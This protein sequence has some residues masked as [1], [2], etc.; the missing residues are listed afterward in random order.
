VNDGVA[1]LAPLQGV[2]DTLLNWEF[3]LPTKQP[4]S[5]VGVCI[6]ACHIARAWRLQRN[7]KLLAVDILES[8]NKL[9]HSYAPTC[10]EVDDRVGGIFFTTLLNDAVK[11]FHCLDMSLREVPDMNIVA[12]A[13]T[14]AGRPV[15]TCQVEDGF[16]SESD[17]YQLADQMAGV[18]NVQP[19][20]AFSGLPQWG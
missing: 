12:N 3:C 18:A 19:C 8:R 20:C 16:T 15:D 14:I 11:T 5:F 7:W 4:G 2:S 1:Y 6:R 9:L 10:A 17:F 13:R